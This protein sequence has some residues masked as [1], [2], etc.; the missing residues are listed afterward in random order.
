MVSKKPKGLTLLQ[1]HLL[2][3]FSEHSEENN[4]DFQARL[5]KRRNG[6]E[7][8][9]AKAVGRAWARFSAGPPIGRLPK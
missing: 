9:T 7:P 6:K 1:D 4:P 8:L 3:P 5:R 2:G